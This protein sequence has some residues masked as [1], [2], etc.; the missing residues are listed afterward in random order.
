MIEEIRKIN[1]TIK[2]KKGA[3]Y[4]EYLII[5]SNKDIPYI[6]LSRIYD[7]ANCS[8]NVDIDITNSIADVYMFSSIPMIDEKTKEDVQK[9]INKLTI[10]IEL[11]DSLK[12]NEGLYYTVYDQMIK[13]RDTLI[14]YM[15][16]AIKK[17]GKI[18]HFENAVTKP[19]K[20]VV[21]CIEKYLN[22]IKSIYPEI[23][24][25]ILKSIQKSYYTITF[26]T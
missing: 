16:D 10:K 19:K 26:K 9:A 8:G 13:E 22:E 7:Q 25:F 15:A 14:K 2:S 3:R 11:A 20:S 17:N 23:F 21:K 1:T 18:R 5:N 12:Q 4:I 6:T 24:K